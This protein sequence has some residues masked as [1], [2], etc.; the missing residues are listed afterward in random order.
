MANPEVIDLN[1]GEWNKVATAVTNA[2]VWGISPSIEYLLTIRETGGTAPANDE[3]E[4]GLPLTE[5]G[6][7]IQNTVAVDVYVFTESEG[8]KVRVHA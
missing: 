3:T 4:E 7:V 6:R 2:Q 1:V 5:F 8:G